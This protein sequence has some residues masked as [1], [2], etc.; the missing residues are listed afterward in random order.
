MSYALV[1]ITLFFLLSIYLALRSKKG[2]TMDH[3]GWSV[4]GR[5]YGALLVFLLSAGEIYTTFTF[6]GGSGWAYGKGPAI[7]YT[8]AVNA[9]MGIFLYWVHPRVWRFAK[10]N[11]IRT[12]SDFFGAKY[13]SQGL[14][15]LISL[16]SIVAMVPLFVLQLKGL[17]IIVSQASYGAIPADMAIWI[18]TIAVTLFVMISGIHGSAWTSALKD[19]MILIVVVFIGVYIP[20]H[21]YGSFGDMFRAIDT[22]SPGFLTFSE[23]GLNI[24]WYISTIFLSVVAYFCWPHYMAAVFTA[25]DEKS[26]K[27]NSILIPAYSLIMLFA[28]FVGYAAILQIPHLDGSMV[29]LSLFEIAKTTFSPLI[30]GLIGAAGML[31]ALVPG[32]MLLLTTSN[33]LAGVVQKALNVSEE[34]RQSGIYARFMVPLVALVS[35]YFIFHS[36]DTLVAIMLLGV[37]IVAQ[38]FPALLMSFRKHNP[39]TATGAMA[40]IIAGVIFLAVT[41]IEHISLSQL[42]PWLG[43]GLEFMNIGIAAFVLNIIVATVVSLLIGRKQKAI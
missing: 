23:Q 16:I 36:N 18:G 40:G 20:L 1:V 38:F 25:K 17:G 27:R 9:F 33:M 7:L 13:Q 14:A 24:P 37:N 12:I 28:F 8:L 21:Y 19:L 3:E 6:L 32:S 2:K 10:Q 39:M 22:A 31:T 26:L 30:V 5:S 43:K 35:L 11:D 15:L 42:F 41:Y 29:D 34:K 4:G